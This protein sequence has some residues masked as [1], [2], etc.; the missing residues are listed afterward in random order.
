MLTDQDNCS[1]ISAAGSFRFL[2]VKKNASG[3]RPEV[4]SHSDG[5]R[6]VLVGR[7]CAT[8][9]RCEERRK[10]AR[11]IPKQRETQHRKYRE[12]KGV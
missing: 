6:Y 11:T 12:R 8:A 10:D 1:V 9:S 7:S 3:W 5:L 2:F 4:Q